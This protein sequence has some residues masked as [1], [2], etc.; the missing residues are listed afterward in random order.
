VIEAVAETPAEVVAEEAPAKPKRAPRKK[1]AD[2][3]AVAEATP[4]AEAEVAAEVAPAKKPARSRKKKA[5]ADATTDVVVEVPAEVPAEPVVA[6]PQAASDVPET[7]DAEDD[8]A[9]ARRGWWQ[10]TFG[11]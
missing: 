2:T 11:E 3:A 1:K 10:R 8:T 7:A 4:E 5:D 9:P 6:A